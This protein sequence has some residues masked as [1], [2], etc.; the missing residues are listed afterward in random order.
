M[1]SPVESNTALI[2]AFG[3]ILDVFRVS[4]SFLNADASNSE[5]KAQRPHKGAI[6]VQFLADKAYQRRADKIRL[7]RKSIAE[8]EQ[9][10]YR[11]TV[12]DLWVQC[13]FVSMSMC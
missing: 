10:R 12:L 11:R 6:D 9:K 7:W 13:Q 8:G 5:H 1:F 4:E 3:Q 2:L